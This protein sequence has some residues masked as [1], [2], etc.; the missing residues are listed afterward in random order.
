MHKGL[1]VGVI[2]GMQVNETRGNAALV[3]HEVREAA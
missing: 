1:K 3:T 2:D